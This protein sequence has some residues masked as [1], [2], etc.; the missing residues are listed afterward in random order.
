MSEFWFDERAAQVAVNFFERVLVHVKGEWAGKPFTLETWQR[1]EVIRPLFGWKRA[2]GTRQV[3]DGLYRDPEEEREEQVE[4]Q[5]SRCFCCLRMT[6]TARRS[7]ARR[8]P[9][10]GEHRVRPGEADGGSVAGAE[11][12]GAGVQE[13]HHGAGDDE[14]LPGAERRRVHEARA[15]CAWGCVRRA[16]RTANRDLWDV[17]TTSTGAR[18]QPLVVAI[19]TAG[20]DRESICWEQHEYARKVRDG[21]VRGRAYFAYIAAAERRM[22]G[23]IRG[24]GRRR[25][26]GSG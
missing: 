26:R 1:E 3:P 15:E 16:A 5:G 14:C 12:T 9:G 13:E 22:T 6:S 18:R 10:P 8:G 17:L 19:T 11:R 24:F 25:T 23:R 4:R 21:I 20:F 7:T 2:D